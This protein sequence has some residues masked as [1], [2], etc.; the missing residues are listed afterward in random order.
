MWAWKCWKIRYCLFRN[1]KQILDNEQFASYVQNCLVSL[2]CT[3]ITIFYNPMPMLK[4]ADAK[5]N[6]KGFSIIH[7]F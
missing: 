6:I 3:V 1:L 4:P 5:S 2:M 7:G